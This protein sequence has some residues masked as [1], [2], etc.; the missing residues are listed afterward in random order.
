MCNR[1]LAA[2]GSFPVHLFLG[3]TGQGDGVRPLH[4]SRPSFR[5]SAKDTRTRLAAE[6]AAPELLKPRPGALGSYLEGHGDLAEVEKEME[7]PYHL[8]F[9]V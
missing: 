8:G 2:R 9:S 5:D 3:G 1:N 6:S 7:L 4:P